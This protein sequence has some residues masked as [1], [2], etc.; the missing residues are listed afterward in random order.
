MARG[1]CRSFPRENTALAEIL[2][3]NAVPG[4]RPDPDGKTVSRAPIF[5]LRVLY[6]G[7]LMHAV[8]VSVGSEL[9]LGQI[10][11]TNSAVI[12][13][14]LAAMGLDLYFK[15]TV[16]DNLGRLTS[17]LREALDRSDVVITT[18]GIGPT[19]DDV[20]REAAA[21]AVGLALDFSE[22]LKE[23]IERFFR[24]RGFTLSPSNRRQAFLPRGAIALEN[25]L[26]TAPGFIVEVGDRCLAV[27]PGV[28][29]E[30]EHL[31]V[32]RVLP[33]V[34]GRYGLGGEIR[35][36]I[37]KVV[38]LGES[39]IGELVGDLMEKGSNPTVGTLAHLG[40][41]DVRIAAKA[42][43][44]DQARR[45]IEPVEATIRQRLGDLIFGADSETL[46]EVVVARARR[47]GV[48]IAVAECGTAGLVAERLSD[49]GG[50]AF[51]GGLVLADTRGAA[52]FGA[53]P[54]A[55]G[56]GVA[57]HQ[58]GR[59]HRLSRRAPRR[60]SGHGGRAGRGRRRSPREPRLPLRGGPAVDPDPC[61]HADARAAAPRPGLGRA[62]ARRA[63]SKRESG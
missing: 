30:M 37:L 44:S 20:R 33:Y 42:A 5:R 3:S 56:Q 45:L 38:G 2:P 55:P 61:G 1:F 49:D 57:R 54:G 28:P 18:G 41:V 50:G 52:R 63:S 27:L 9:L 17:V 40:Q 4:W 14:H 25:P 29:R 46:E 21:Q 34:K 35:L 48:R 51:A 32:T 22:P 15:T 31:L 6:N 59:G 47:L 26:G 60:S 62:D 24:A 19:A 16:G 13:R 58:G 12:G 39:R 7:A 53:D 36:R 23:Q 11:D 10:V 43:D 8:I